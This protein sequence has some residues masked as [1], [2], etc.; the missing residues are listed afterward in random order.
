M[1]HNVLRSI[2][3]NIADSLASGVGLMIGHYELDVF[4]EAARSPEGALTVDF[5]A[6]RCVEGVASASLARAIGLYRTALLDLCGK[7][8]TTVSAFR[9][10]T[11][12]YSSD[13]YGSRFVVTIEDQRGRRSVDAYVGTPGRRVM[14]RDGLGRPRRT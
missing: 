8:R 4:G 2:A 14:A 11:A 10:L 7:H 1:K 5:L 12:R 3:H 6:G 9:V 13:P